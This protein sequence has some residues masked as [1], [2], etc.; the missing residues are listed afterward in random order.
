M[1]SLVFDEI[2]GHYEHFFDTKIPVLG[3][4]FEYFR[5]YLRLWRSLNL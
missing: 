4:F 2:H 3:V 5:P 1:L